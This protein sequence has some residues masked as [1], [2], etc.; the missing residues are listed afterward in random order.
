M[1]WCILRLWR[2]TG[3]VVSISNRIRGRPRILQC[4][5]VLYLIRLVRHRLEW[6][7]DELLVLHL[8]NT[9]RFISAHYATIH[10]ELERVGVSLKKHV[11]IV[12]AM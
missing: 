2:E 12:L 3:D 9:N 5:D 8:R 6:F 11:L 10:R 7:L 4:N 1:F